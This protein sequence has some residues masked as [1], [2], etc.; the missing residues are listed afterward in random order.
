MTANQNIPALRFPDFKGEWD[1]NLFGSYTQFI[2]TNSLSRENLNYEEGT[3]FNIHYG[4]IHTKFRS[5]F[6]ISRENVPRIKPEAI[7]ERKYENSFL[8]H[9][10][11]VFADASEDY[12][13]IGKCIEIIDT[14][15]KKIVAGLHTLHA[16]LNSG[17]FS[18]GF[19]GWLLQTNKVKDQIKRLAQG[20]KVLSITA[21]RLSEIEINFPTLTEQQKIASF[22]T[23]V[24]EKIQQLTRK[25]A[26][27][28]Q[29]K[30][31]LM[32]QIFSREIR[33]KPDA[34]GEFGEW[35]EKMLGD[36]G[37]IKM[38]RRIFNEQTSPVDEIPF[39]KIGSFGKIADAY[40]SR[41]LYIDYRKKYPFPEKGDILISAAGTIGRLVIY[42]GEDAYY[43]DSNIVW[44]DNKNG[45]VLNEFLFY[46]L[47]IAKFKTEGGTIQRLY[48]SIL[49]STKFSRPSIPEQ[50]KIASFLSALDEKIGQVGQQLEK[51]KEWKKGLLQGM[52]V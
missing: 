49:K 1:T 3:I 41:E 37:E 50:Q 23:A 48:N 42:N 27:L 30:Q 15:N 52:F 34:G 21:G 32:Q 35:E 5:Q 20:S 45:V 29:Y 19:L 36:I 6:R 26:L 47:Q 12:N 2:P 46:V 38:C 33:F 18:K 51:A 17:T 16:R 28:E 11:L 44:I 4:D 40:I 8:R 10:D 14:D 39:Y 7:D 22:L 13:D 25:K 31:G 24:D 9:G 43:Q